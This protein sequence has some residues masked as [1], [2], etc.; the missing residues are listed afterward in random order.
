MKPVETSPMLRGEQYQQTHKAAVVAILGDQAPPVSSRGQMFYNV[1]RWTLRHFVLEMCKWAKDN[2]QCIPQE[3]DIRSWVEAAN[4][5][6]VPKREIVIAATP[7]KLD[8]RTGSALTGG[9]YHEAFHTLR[10]CRRNLQVKEMMDLILPRWAKVPDWSGYYK[11][12]QDFSNIIE[13]IRIERR[14]R[15][16]FPGTDTKLHDLQD[17]ILILESQARENQIVGRGHGPKPDQKSSLSTILCVY[18]DVGLGY[19]TQL[20]REALAKYRSKD[21][22]A[23]TFCLSGPLTANLKECIALPNSDD[24]GCLRLTLDALGIMHHESKLPDPA[25]DPDNDEHQPGGNYKIK[26]PKC[27][28]KGSK[29]VVRPKSDGNGGKVPGMGILTC[30]VCGHQEEV[31]IKPKGGGGGKGGDPEDQPKF[32]G[33][34]DPPSGSGGGKGPKSDKPQPG[35]G[36]DGDGD[37]GDEGDEKDGKGKGKG[38]GDEGEGEGDEGDEAGDEAE[39]GSSSQGQ[40]G[41][42]GPGG[43]HHHDKDPVKGTD[44]ASLLQEALQAAE[45]DLGMLNAE[46]ALGDKFDEAK[47]KEMKDEGGVKSGEAVWRPLDPNLDVVK[48]VEPSTKGK[49]FDGQQADALYASVRNEATY[50]RARVRLIIRALRMTGVVHGLPKGRKLSG[51]FLVDTRLA[52]LEN[53]TP[54][55]AYQATDESVDTTM[56]AVLILDESGSMSSDLPDVTRVMMSISEP[57]DVLGCPT[58]AV[59][60]R[61]GERWG[62]GSYATPLPGDQGQYHRTG[63]IHYDVFKWFHEGF[64]AIKWRFANTRATGG[65]PMADGL[66]FG[67]DAL[68]KREETHR[69]LF[70]VTDGQPNG[71][72]AAI[73]KRQIRLAKEANIHVIGVG[74][75]NDAR[76]VKTLFPDYV[77]ARSIQEMPKALIDKLNEL[78]DLKIASRKANKTLAK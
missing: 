45:G 12:I 30:T 49:A 57:L 11:L 18:R 63:A 70:L 29:L 78:V 3:K 10:S 75:G 76:F 42:S 5:H 27:G 13:D 64:R 16:Q 61:D 24:K 8:H 20:Q 37:E 69:V 67:L 50:L 53:E 22:Q 15:E 2:P 74:I 47:S 43:G 7:R 14:G 36:D 54:K 59:G 26:C 31:Q 56:A 46:T 44:W 65:T 17:F 48:T 71:G 62:H 19:N 25:N 38:D 21:E 32:E 28:A 34:D 4:A 41:N 35:Q 58:M 51:R 72:H 39:S 52:S 1:D 73:M 55:R 33:F 77:W 40:P 6:K 9:A 23:V 66:Q 60:F 68:D